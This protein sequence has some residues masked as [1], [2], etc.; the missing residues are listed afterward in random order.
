MKIN[1]EIDKER[2]LIIETWPEQ[3]IVEDFEKVKLSE[4]S[5]TDFNSAYNSNN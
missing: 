5:D 2:E 3:I 4:F 1:Y